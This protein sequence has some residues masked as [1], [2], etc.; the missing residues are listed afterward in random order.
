[1][2]SDLEQRLEELKTETAQLEH[3]R[4][5]FPSSKG[6]DF[7]DIDM[8]SQYTHVNNNICTIFLILE[9][10]DLENDSES[11]IL[12]DLQDIEKGVNLL[13]TYFT[14]LQKLPGFANK[15]FSKGFFKNHCDE[16]ITSSVAN[17]VIYANDKL[18]DFDCVEYE[19]THNTGTNPDYLNAFGLNPTTRVGWQT[20][21]AMCREDSF[22]T[23]SE[24]YDPTSIT[25]AASNPKK[26]Q[27]IDELAIKAREAGIKNDL[28]A[29]TTAYDA[30]KKILKNN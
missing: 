14:L 30:I 22:K 27:K 15:E 2:R 6:V 7:E 23:Y 11:E 19:S 18:G 29:A 21:T 25:M 1:M 12:S 13:D 17:Y 4:T 20:F 16:T 28:A 8:I 26:V 9:V 24:F 3:L 10:I 5:N